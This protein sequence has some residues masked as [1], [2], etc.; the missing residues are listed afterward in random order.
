LGN[1]LKHEFKDCKDG[2]L[3]NKPGF[4][5]I[6]FVKTKLLSEE[7]VITS[8]NKKASSE[9]TRA[10]QEKEDEIALMNIKLKDALKN[11]KTTD[12]NDKSDTGMQD[13][14]LLLVK[15]KGGEGKGRGNNHNKGKT[16][17]QEPDWNAQWASLEKWSSSESNNDQY[18]NQWSQQPKGKGKGEAKTLR[19]DIHQRFGHSTDWCFDNPNRTGGAPLPSSDTWCT[20][21]NRSGHVASSCYATSIRIPSK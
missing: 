3:Y 19:C 14:A 8:K 4:D 2:I 16:R 7:A 11:A 5:T 13:K 20:T 17:W 6:L 21:C 15:G 1:G 12:T 10:V 9:H 18:T